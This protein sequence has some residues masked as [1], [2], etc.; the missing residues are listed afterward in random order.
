MSPT[1]EDCGEVGGGGGGGGF[2]GHGDAGDS[3]GEGTAAATAAEMAE[4]PKFDCES[5]EKSKKSSGDDC[6]TFGDQLSRQLAGVSLE[7][8]DVT[9]ASTTATTTTEMSPST[10]KE[11]CRRANPFDTVGI[12]AAIAVEDRVGGAK[13]NI[14]VDHGDSTALSTILKRPMPTK[15]SSSAVPF[16]AQIYVKGTLS[17]TYW[18]HMSL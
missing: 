3:A 5:D 2:L 1:K 13:P 9:T 11:L 12:G 15:I 18:S 4:K 14:G 6:L 8:S 16:E 17:Q 10:L 7:S